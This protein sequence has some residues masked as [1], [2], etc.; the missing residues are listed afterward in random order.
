MTKMVIEKYG[1]TKAHYFSTGKDKPLFVIHALSPEEMRIIGNALNDY[2]KK[3]KRNT[4]IVEHYVTGKQLGQVVLEQQ[5]NFKEYVTN[6]T[7]SFTNQFSSYP[8]FT[9]ESD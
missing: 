7:R 8:E 5:N 6:L 2:E 3:V 9:I 4:A 1:E